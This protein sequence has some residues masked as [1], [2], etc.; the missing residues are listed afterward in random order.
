MIL[1]F[2]GLLSIFSNRI[3]DK[4]EAFIYTILSESAI[5]WLI[6]ELFSVFE[7]LSA[8]SLWICWG[9]VGI[10]T[11]CVG[12][13]SDRNKSLVRWCES[14]LSDKGLCISV[15][16]F[17]IVVLIA[18][19]ATIP[20]NWDSMTYH[21]TRIACW[22]QN[23]SVAHY[24][25]MDPRQLSSPQ[26]GDFINLHIYLMTGTDRL[27]NLTQ[28]MSYIL[29]GVIVFK[30]S[31]LIGNSRKWNIV[32]MI[33]FWSTPIAFC[34]A[35]TT[36]VDLYAGLICLCF[37]YLLIPYLTTEDKLTFDRQSAFRTLMLGVA[38]GLGFTAKP[39][40]C[41]GMFF[42]VLLL[43]ITCI[44]RKDSVLI[45]IEHI[46]IA[47]VSL[48]VVI[49]PELIRNIVTYNAILPSK[50]GGRQ[51]IGSLHPRHILV[52]FYKTFTFNLPTKAIYGLDDFIYETGLKWA[53]FLDIDI[54]S[55]V[56]AEDGVE[57][58]VKASPRFGCDVAANPVIVWLMIATIILT[59]LLA[60]RIDWKDFRVKYFITAVIS[61]LVF[62][63]LLRWE[64][65][66]SRYMI[67]YFAILSP[68]IMGMFT[69][70]EEG[71]DS[72]SN[73]RL[74]IN[75]YS[76]AAGMISIV[77]FLSI[78]E[79]IG[80]VYFQHGL[81]REQ[82]SMGSSQYGYFYENT[83]WYEQYE[84]LS[85]YIDESGVTNIGIIYQ[86]NGFKYP[87]YS[88]SDSDIIIKEIMVSD[89]TSVYEE[90]DYLP[91]LILTCGSGTIESAENIT[92]HNNNYLKYV[93][94]DMFEI[95]YIQ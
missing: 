63:G 93:S 53:R 16:L 4:K 30:L 87:I 73:S 37:T 65:F 33:L 19:V 71:R 42:F 61:F 72:S 39:S 56:I 50:V 23:R 67:S 48:I 34:E 28:S 17:S 91:D 44:R 59:I 11:I 52:N 15:G 62:C 47:L 38:I 81:I 41:I 54:N 95:Y 12:F 51:L 83:S 68:A 8:T 85:E 7:V 14:V 40:V 58:V 27:L 24:A 82:H 92:Y 74:K 66:V 69:L 13:L 78:I 18:S 55:E 94:E 84:K 5:L 36:Q 79:G 21:L 77:V 35:F 6:T 45:C 32:A 57:Y 2:A 90:E 29:S 88:M 31:E 25:T 22:A 10:S 86:G 3:E 20:Y 43:L 70:I 64:K 46:G 89:E 49:I 1:T 26:M 76:F 75:G 60:K 80:L 9:V